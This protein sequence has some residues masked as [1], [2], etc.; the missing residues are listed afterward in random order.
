M[1]VYHVETDGWTVV[2]S[3]VFTRDGG[4]VAVQR[5]LFRGDVATD[6]CRDRFGNVIDWD[7][8]E[9]LTLD[10]V[11]EAPGGRRWHDSAHLITACPGHHNGASSWV[12]AHREQ[13][14]DL[15]RRLYPEVWA[16]HATA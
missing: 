11:R 7:D 15:L 2:R 14:R 1:I 5:E 3:A 6:P 16:S 13:I 9:Y 8:W 10:H 12:T 4:C